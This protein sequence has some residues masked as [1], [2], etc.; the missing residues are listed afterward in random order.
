MIGDGVSCSG[1]DMNGSGAAGCSSSRAAAQGPAPGR[2]FWHKHV[3][4]VDPPLDG[5][6][7]YKARRETGRR[8][9]D[10]QFRATPAELVRRHVWPV[11]SR[12]ANVSDSTCT[13]YLRQAHLSRAESDTVNHGRR[14]CYVYLCIC[15]YV[16]YVLVW[17]AIFGSSEWHVD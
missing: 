7:P 9:S 8:L 12:A 14:Y 1:H 4:D 3:A 13:A 10:T 16:A 5:G 11:M 15:R 17:R 6:G 2:T